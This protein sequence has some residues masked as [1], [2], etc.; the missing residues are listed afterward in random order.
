MKIYKFLRLFWV[1]RC[2]HNWVEIIGW[3]LFDNSKYYWWRTRPKVPH[4]CSKC[5]EWKSFKV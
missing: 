1:P 5:G 4:K 3:R 2:G